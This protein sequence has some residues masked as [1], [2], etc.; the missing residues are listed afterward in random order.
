[1]SGHRNRHVREG[2]G[3]GNP[4]HKRARP[5]GV[6]HPR[7]ADHNPLNRGGG[8]RGN[9]PA[10]GHPGTARQ[11]SER[12]PRSTDTDAG[13]VWPAYGNR[14]EA[15]WALE[16]GRHHGIGLTGGDVRRKTSAAAEGDS[17]PH[18]FN[19]GYGPNRFMSVADAVR[20]RHG[21]HCW[22]YP[23]DKTMPIAPKRARATSSHPPIDFRISALKANAAATHSV[24]ASAERSVWR[25]EAPRRS[26]KAALGV[27]LSN[28]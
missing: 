7:A 14:G 25:P 18:S 9:G 2:S 20:P 1:M 12:F 16:S 15:G 26:H 3:D 19:A 5:A 17:A 6:G 22:R 8:A 28:T 11:A 24:I 4:S 10:A 23:A 21:Q 27:V 13:V